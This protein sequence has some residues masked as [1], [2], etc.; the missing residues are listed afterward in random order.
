MVSFA[1]SFF[2]SKA[3]YF[4]PP[5]FYPHRGQAIRTAIDLGS[6]PNTQIGRYPSDFSLFEIGT[7]DDQTGLFAPVTP[8]SLG[9]VSALLPKEQAPLPLFRNAAE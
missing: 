5:F 4:S 3:G 2:D 1:F 6:D 7:F 8:L 9:V